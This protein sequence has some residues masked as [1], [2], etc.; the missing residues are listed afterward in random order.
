MSCTSS[1]AAA[2]VFNC[3]LPPH[4]AD[5]VAVE[6][7]RSAATPPFAF[8]TAP[9]A[10]AGALPLRGLRPHR[11]YWLSCRMHNASAGTEVSGWSSASPPVACT[12]GTFTWQFDCMLPYLCDIFVCLVC[13]TVLFAL[14]VCAGDGPAASRGQHW[15]G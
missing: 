14:L 12:T 4:A 8:T 2:L 11:T 9:V 13:F 1:A 3:S 7:R 15:T 6:L 10:L 5:T